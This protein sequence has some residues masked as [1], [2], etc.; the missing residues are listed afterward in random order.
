MEKFYSKS[1]D[2]SRSAIACCAGLNL[3]SSGIFTRSPFLFEISL[4]VI[5]IFT[6]Y[7][8]CMSMLVILML[9]FL[10]IT[11]NLLNLI[12]PSH[13]QKQTK[14]EM[15]VVLLFFLSQLYFVYQ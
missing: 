4:H 8:L 13:K 10:N 15:Q 5:K 14:K 2:Q 9:K 1:Q 11:S 3:D 6:S 7:C 12:P